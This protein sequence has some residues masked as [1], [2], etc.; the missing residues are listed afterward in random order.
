MKSPFVKTAHVAAHVGGN[1]RA[2]RERQ[3]WS[4]QQL[5]NRCVA[6]DAPW[7]TYGVLGYLENPEGRTR[8]RMMSVDDL[9]A[10]AKALDVAPAELLG[11]YAAKAEVDHA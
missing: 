2:V 5:A 10:I 9:V 11:E 3:G 8:H 4:T 7:L 6:V 1:V